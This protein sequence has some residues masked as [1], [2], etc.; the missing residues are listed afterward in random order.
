MPELSRWH[1]ELQRSVAHS[2]DLLDMM[3]H[4]LKHP[5]YLPVFPFDQRDFKPGIVRLANRF[6][7]GRRGFRSPATFGLDEDTRTQLCQALTVH[8]PP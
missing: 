6:D 1:I 7:L 4:R 2:L 8:L 5:P 3:A